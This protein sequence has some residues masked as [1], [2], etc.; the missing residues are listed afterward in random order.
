[1]AI[2]ERGEAFYAKVHRGRGR[3]EHV[4]TFRWDEHGGK[5]GA[6]R[7]AERAEAVAHERRRNRKS[8]ETCDEFAA[9]WPDD[10][11]IV[12]HGPT[13]GQRK[14]DKTLRGYRDELKPFVREFRGIK[15]ADVDRPM[16]RKYANER[17]R[18]AVVVRNMFSDAV[19]DGLIDANPFANL[20]LEQARGRSQHTTITE[21]EF[22]GQARRPVPR[23]H[24]GPGRLLDESTGTEQPGS[25]LRALSV[26]KPF[27]HYVFSDFSQECV[28]ALSARVGTRA[29]VEIVRGDANDPDH[30]ERV[31]GLLNVRALVI[32]YLDPARP[33]DLRWTTV[34][35][36]AT[37]F[38]YIDL[39]INLPV[40]S[41][42]RAILGAYRAGGRA[43]GAAGRFLNYSAPHE[44]LQP[45][46]DHP[47]TPA[48]IEAI[49]RHY[50]E[51]LRALGF[52]KPARRTITFPP[53]NP[54]YDVL[55]VSRHDRG[56]E[57]WNRTNPVPVDPV[58]PQLSLLNGEGGG[59]DDSA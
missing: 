54:Y 24:S 26:R 2:V 45:N 23:A 20:Q 35:Y 6:R 29:D 43:P 21:E 10:Y 49:R 40:N 39:I 30:L 9:R 3:Y 13:R 31:A 11:P 44:L 28:A 42:M 58:D 34:E 19:D 15:L 53:E 36:L 16:A 17:P 18:S 14:S 32:A 59:A 41:L 8:I 1:M 7:A 33:Q 37:R 12:K 25:P 50:D 38:K 56:L 55:L 4:G 52:K 48:T 5:R 47:S 46:A 51:Q 57:L 27:T 22:R